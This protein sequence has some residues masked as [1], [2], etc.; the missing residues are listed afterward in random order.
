[1]QPQPCR[2]QK[3]ELGCHL[4]MIWEGS[5]GVPYEGDQ[6]DDRCVILFSELG[7]DTRTMTYFFD[8][9]SSNTSNTCS[10]RLFAVRS[11]LPTVTRTGSRWNEAA[12][13]R[14][15][16][17]HVALTR[18]SCERPDTRTTLSPTH[19]GLSTFSLGGISNNGPNVILETFIQHPI[20]FV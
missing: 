12:S 19:Q 10:T 16:S 7:T 1:M 15:E 2:G 18:G 8:L 20:G 5:G 9:L 4:M 13:F 17:G 3:R 14:T 11:S 6:E